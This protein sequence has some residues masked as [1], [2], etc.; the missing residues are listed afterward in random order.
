VP[1]ARRGEGLLRDSYGRIGRVKILGPALVARRNA[2]STTATSRRPDAS[3]EATHQSQAVHVRTT[4]T[5]TPAAASLPVPAQLV[6][7]P[8]QRQVLPATTPL[9]DVTPGDVTPMGVTPVG[10][11]P[12]GLASVDVLPVRA[13]CV[14]ATSDD[15]AVDPRLTDIA[16]DT[17]LIPAQPAISSQPHRVEA[18]ADEGRS[19][20]TSSPQAQAPTSLTTSEAH[21]N[22][23]AERLR[24]IARSHVQAALARS[25]GAATSPSHHTGHASSL[26]ED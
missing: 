11:S 23:A 24:R 6:Q 19:T 7:E 18:M 1:I 16:M 8:A 22:A 9:V 12:L 25:R 2:Y 10:V 14:N 26:V 15:H 4:S 21:S 13:A 20:S 17:S 5:A 3:A